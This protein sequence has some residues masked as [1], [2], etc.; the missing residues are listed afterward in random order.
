MRPIPKIL[1]VDDLQNN[2]FALEQVLQNLNVE[3][4]AAKSGNDALKATLHEKF[5]LAILDI[6]MPEMN[7]F[8]LTSILG[9]DSKTKDIP[10][11]LL[12]AF[13][14]DQV[15]L[16]VGDDSRNIDFLQKPFEPSTLL[17]KIRK[18]LN[19]LPIESPK[20]GVDALSERSNHKNK[21]ESVENAPLNTRLAVQLLPSPKDQDI[22]FIL[23]KN[24]CII[25]TSNLDFPVGADISV[26]RNMVLK[27]DIKRIKQA[28]VACKK[29]PY[30][31]QIIEIRLNV[32]DGYPSWVQ[33]ELFP[34][35]DKQQH[36]DGM[37]CYCKSI[38][39]EKILESFHNALLN[40]HH[41]R[42]QNYAFERLMFTLSQHS[43]ADLTLFTQVD[44]K[45]GGEVCTAC[46]KE[47]K[48]SIE[49]HTLVKEHS[50]YINE[51]GVVHLNLRQLIV[52]SNELKLSVKSVIGYPVYNF[53]GQFVGSIILYFCKRVEYLSMVRNMLNLT[54]MKVASE[55]ERRKTDLKTQKLLENT[56]RQ[57][58]LFKE[59]S[60]I[61]SHNIRSSV[62]NLKGLVS[63][64]EY[65]ANSEVVLPLVKESV[66]NLSNTIEHTSHLLQVENVKPNTKY[67]AYKLLEN[68]ERVINSLSSSSLENKIIF[69]VNI[70][71]ELAVNVIPAYMDSILNNLVSNAIKF[72]ITAT[73]NK[74]VI[75]ATKEEQKV[76]LNIK[77]F[78]I[79]IDLEH[80]SDK[81]FT[82]GS[83][84]NSTYKGEGIGLYI[85]KRHIEVMKGE[86]SVKSKLNEGA[87]F[88]IILNEN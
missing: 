43:R 65:K 76:Y 1:I 71:K 77:D 61:T 74:I 24:L 46:Y 33:L 52:F 34:M 26:I 20:R 15:D 39:E 23:N 9:E 64:L 68:I 58:E 6:Q 7:G 72:G 5:D 29:R 27:Q 51:N 82:L 36:F 47:T 13:Y 10:I 37:Y 38:I 81:I 63:M 56:Q 28:F 21:E 4:T 40:I 88:K 87:E 67:K 53:E 85:T 75:S 19:I 57:N 54:G 59:F 44:D 18:L 41:N 70:T 50:R 79:G 84:L 12:S 42:F 22:V 55:Y 25:Q 73:N 45:Q 69:E 14:S 78:G 62:S 35:L 48:I 60:F 3:T 80:S 11:I 49:N 66:N 17:K 86:I 32:E 16:P 8:E 31:K 2:L 30:E 83:R